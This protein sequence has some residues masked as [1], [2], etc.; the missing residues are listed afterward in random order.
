MNSISSTAAIT[1]QKWICSFFSMTGLL[2]LCFPAP[3]PRKETVY[4]RSSRLAELDGIRPII[5]EAM[6]RGCNDPEFTD[7]IHP[8]AATTPKGRNGRVAPPSLLPC[9]S[10]K[11]REKF[12]RDSPRIE[13]SLLIKILHATLRPNRRRGWEPAGKLENPRIAV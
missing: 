4:G 11:L 1:Y 12:F 10:G 7:P 8:S 9:R 5:G 13:K 2:K 6:A 3:E